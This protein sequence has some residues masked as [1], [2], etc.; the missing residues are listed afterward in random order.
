MNDWIQEARR[1][2]DYNP[3]VFRWS[4]R[5]SFNNIVGQM[6]AGQWRIAIPANLRESKQSKERA[7]YPVR[8]PEPTSGISGSREME[9]QLPEY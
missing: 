3:A 4:F 5:T 1:L 2:A 9:S 7:L 6:L 8:E